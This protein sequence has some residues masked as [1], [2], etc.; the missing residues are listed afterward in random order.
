[1]TIAANSTHEELPVTGTVTQQRRLGTDGPLVSPIGLGVMSFVVSA[2]AEEEN[3]AAD[4][5]GRAIDLGITF[6]DTADVYGP[7]IS[8]IL[9]G[10]AINGRRDSVTIATK[11][12]NA[13]DRD[14]HPR[15][16]PSR[17]RRPSA[18][19]TPCTR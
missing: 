17:A 11:F 12:G 16:C 7:E 19:R 15:V 2:E 8:E 3:R 13:L 4:I 18:G 10:R 14:P 9:L 6:F 5:V 1:M